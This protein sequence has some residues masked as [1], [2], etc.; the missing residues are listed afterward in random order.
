MAKVH[1]VHGCL[2]RRSAQGAFTDPGVHVVADI[3]A[4]TALVDLGLDFEQLSQLV[5]ELNRLR[6]EHLEVAVELANVL[7]ADTVS[8][9]A[10]HCGEGQQRKIGAELFGPR[11]RDVIRDLTEKVEGTLPFLLVLAVQ[12]LSAPLCLLVLLLPMRISLGVTTYL[13]LGRKPV[14]AC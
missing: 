10:A 6:P 7:R 14:R 13:W 5:S 3:S 2:R 12:T 4:E 9:L 8:E 1:T 11:R